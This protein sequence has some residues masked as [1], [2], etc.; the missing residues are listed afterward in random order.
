MKNINRKDTMIS[1]YR[2]KVVPWSDGARGPGGRFGRP[3]YLSSEE[4]EQAK[5]KKRNEI[6]H[7]PAADLVDDAPDAEKLRKAMRI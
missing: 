1:N 4:A 3:P 5:E 6:E 7:T 2:G